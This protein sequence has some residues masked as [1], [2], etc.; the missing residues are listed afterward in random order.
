MCE[1]VEA[2]ELYN[3][4]QNERRYYARQTTLFRQF[5]YEMKW[6]TFVPEYCE[7]RLFPVAHDAAQGYVRE[8]CGREV[9]YLNV[10]SLATIRECAAMMVEYFTLEKSYGN[11]WVS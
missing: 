1:P 10:F 7:A 4:L 5:E 8:Y 3:Y 9:R 6:N 2:I 11:S